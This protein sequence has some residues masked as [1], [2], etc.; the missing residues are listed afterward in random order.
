V[1]TTDLGERAYPVDEVYTS[2]AA[3]AKNKR[4]KVVAETE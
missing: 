3:T 2:A 4:R 1:T